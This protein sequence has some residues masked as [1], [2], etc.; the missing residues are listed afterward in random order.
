MLESYDKEIKKLDRTSESY[1]NDMN[2]AFTE[3]QDGLRNTNIKGDTLR[4]L[5]AYALADDNRKVCNSMLTVLYDKNPQ[6]FMELF[7]KGNKIEKRTIPF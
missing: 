7:K 1:A 2:S 4:T 6:K 5:I 3:I